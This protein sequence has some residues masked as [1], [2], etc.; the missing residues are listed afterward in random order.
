VRTAREIFD[1]YRAKL[2]A[3]AEAFPS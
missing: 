3:L 2:P 1:G